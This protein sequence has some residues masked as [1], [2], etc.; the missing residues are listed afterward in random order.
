MHADIHL[1]LHELRA[2]ELH[3]DAADAGRHRRA[4]AGPPR[5]PRRALRAQLGWTMVELGLR[6]V[7][8]HPARTTRP[9][10]AA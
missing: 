8:A 3:R 9:A 4:V 6:M 7:A 10:A 2:T 5:P 1:H